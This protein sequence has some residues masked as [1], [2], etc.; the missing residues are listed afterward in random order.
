M[1][2]FRLFELLNSH[3]FKMRLL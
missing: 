1:S 2:D 3:C